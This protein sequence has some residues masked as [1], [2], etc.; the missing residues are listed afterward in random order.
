MNFG[1]L[2]EKCWQFLGCHDTANRIDW[3]RQEIRD[4]INSAQDEITSAAPFLNELVRESYFDVV[5]GVVEGT[6][7]VL[8]IVTPTAPRTGKIYTL[9]DWCRRPLSFWTEDSTAHKVEMKWP[10]SFDRDGSRNSNLAPLSVGPF[11]LTPH[12][13]SSAAGTTDASVSASEAS[14]SITAAQAAASDVGKMVRLNG[15]DSDYKITVVTSPGAAATLTTDRAIRGRL[16]GLGTTGV[17]ADYSAIGAVISPPGRYRIFMNPA[18]T[19]TQTLYYRYMAYARRLVNPTDVPE[20]PVEQHHLLWKGALRMIAGLDRKDSA[21]GIYTNEF[22]RAVAQYREADVDD[23]DS[24]DVP[25]YE[26]ALTNDWHGSI[27]ADV[28]RR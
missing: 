26:S 8:L 10:R 3:R 16:T 4:A 17:G 7:E 2:E 1:N 12:P 5:T 14:T 27:P 23:V 24:N 15:E 18:P 28:D 9:S 20:L 11:N 21:Y 19:A 25:N 22:D 6:A 13:R